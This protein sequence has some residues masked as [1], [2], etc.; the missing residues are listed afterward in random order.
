[1]KLACV[2][3]IYRFNF[4]FVV[5][6]LF[7]EWCLYL[8]LNMQNNEKNY[9]RAKSEETEKQKKSYS[10]AKKILVR[11]HSF[12]KSTKESKFW[13]STPSSPLSTNKFWSKL[14]PLSDL[15]NWHWPQ[16][17]THTHTHTLDNFENFLEKFNSKVNIAT[18]SL[19]VKYKRR[20]RMKTV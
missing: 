11:G 13:T 6:R 9:E 5:R 7:L 16:T 18:Y 20:F 14:T 2:W 12:M 4:K 1:M 8:L 17:N 10:I 15:L 19:Q 3:C